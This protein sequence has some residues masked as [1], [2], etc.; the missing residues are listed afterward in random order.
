[1]NKNNNNCFNQEIEHLNF[2]SYIHQIIWQQLE[3]YVAGGFD[4]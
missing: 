1:M 2:K 3:F 4:G